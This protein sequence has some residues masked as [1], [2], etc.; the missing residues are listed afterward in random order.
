VTT[1]LQHT[2]ARERKPRAALAAFAVAARARG[3]AI[4]LPRGRVFVRRAV[5]TR[6]AVT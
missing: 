3:R 5:F 4:A 2:S 6:F 1:R